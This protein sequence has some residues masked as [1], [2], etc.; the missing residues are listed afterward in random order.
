MSSWTLQVAV[1]A[2]GEVRRRE[3]VVEGVGRWAEDRPEERQHSE[4]PG[5]KAKKEW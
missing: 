1:E 3:T 4:E 5:R 2:R